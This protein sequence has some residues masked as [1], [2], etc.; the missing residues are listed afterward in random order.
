M[1]TGYTGPRIWKQLAHLQ[2]D[3]LPLVVAYSLPAFDQE[4]DIDRE[5]ELRSEAIGLA[6]QILVGRDPATWVDR[7]YVCSDRR[8]PALLFSAS[9]LYSGAYAIN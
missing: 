2:V 8:M 5:A 9:F 3:G 6:M 7:P 4:L 1:Q